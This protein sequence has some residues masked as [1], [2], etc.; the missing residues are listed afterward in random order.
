MMSNKSFKKRIKL[1]LVFS[2]NES[3]K[4]KKFVKSKKV[5]RVNGKCR[6]EKSKNIY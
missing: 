6:Y 1:D 5:A 2:D 4:N 3:K